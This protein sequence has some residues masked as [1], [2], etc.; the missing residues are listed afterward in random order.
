MFWGVMGVFWD[1]MGWDMNDYSAAK[2]D[3][4]AA[5]WNLR[6]APLR[7]SAPE[8]SLPV[9]IWRLIT[10]PTLLYKAG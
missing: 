9:A 3:F 10:W 1:V 8:W 5:P 2:K 6:H 4:A 7:Q